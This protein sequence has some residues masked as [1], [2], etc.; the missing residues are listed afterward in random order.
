[1][2]INIWNKRRRQSRK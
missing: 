2:D 1:M